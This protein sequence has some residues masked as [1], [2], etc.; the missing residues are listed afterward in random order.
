MADKAIGELPVADDLY[1]DSLLVVEQQREARSI[2]GR[3]IRKFAVAAVDAD[4]Q[5]AVDAADDAEKSKDA[6]AA[7]AAAAAQSAD[8][9]ETSADK[10]EQYSGK[11]PIIQNNTWWTWDAD[12]HIYVDTGEASRGNLM[13]AV[14]WIDPT[15]GELYM[16]TD[17]EYDGPGFRLT[18]NGDLEVVLNAG[19]A[20]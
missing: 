3:L 20:A 1:D 7:S 9:A 8:E 18:E 19:V 12:Q 14:F 17:D 16:Y 13:Y 10:A 5:R 6:A 15:D 11:P 2:E 4:V